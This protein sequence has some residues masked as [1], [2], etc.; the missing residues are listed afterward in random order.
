MQRADRVA[1]EQRNNCCNA[2]LKQGSD[3]LQQRA[4]TVE[5]EREIHYYFANTKVN[6]NADRK[7]EAHVVQN[8]LQ[9]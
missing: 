6:L 5:G 3:M 8:L 9:S 1:D 7:V 4:G 2:A